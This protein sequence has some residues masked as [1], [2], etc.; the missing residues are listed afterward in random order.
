MA[1]IPL[2]SVVVPCFNHARFLTEALDSIGA[3]SR[4]VE[5]VVV[6][7]GSTDGSGA[8]A[9]A[10]AQR[11]VNGTRMRVVRQPRTGVSAARNRGFA[12]SRGALV[13]FLD[14]DDHLAP[15]A[16]DVGARALDEHPEAVFVYGRCQMMDA[17]GALLATPLLPRIARHPYHELLRNNYIWTP[18]NVMFRRSVLERCGAFDLTMS[19]SADY[20]LYLRIARTYPIYDH[21]Q[22]MAHYRRHGANMSS[23]TVKMLRETLAVL[24]RQWPYVDGNPEATA[25]Y[26][27]G[28]RHWQEFFGAHLVSEIRAH[29]RERRWAPAVRKAFVLGALH[30]GALAHHARQ[31][32]RRT[33]ELRRPRDA[34]A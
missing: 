20:E 25:A 15:N 24:R 4:A 17:Y 33:I 21:G 27:E 31:Q 12:E 30:P 26:R 16:L 32:L 7:D 9:D 34:R 22:L 19:R 6:D 14:A 10:C 2:I 13:V 5:V 29:A 3:H 23:N 1:G 8:I 18:A 28:W 11:A